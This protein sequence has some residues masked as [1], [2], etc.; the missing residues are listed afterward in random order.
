MRGPLPL[1][2]ILKLQYCL[3]GV[4]GFAICLWVTW[5]VVASG[6]ALLAQESVKEFEGSAEA[7]RHFEQEI[8]PLLI[9]KCISCHGE[10]KQEGGLRLDSHEA[11]LKGGESGSLL[12]ESGSADDS[13][14]L[15]A[16][17]YE[18]F[19]MPP[20]GPLPER[21]VAQFEKWL[22]TGAPWPEQAKL[23]AESGSIT[24]EDRQWW[25]FQP[26][27][28]AVPPAL[29]DS[30]E[31]RFVRNPIDQFVVA[32]LHEK[33]M[34]PAEQAS[35]EVLLRRLYFD[36]LGVPPS[37][38]EVQEFMADDAAD[39]W[40]RRV[41]QLL[42]DPRYGEHWARFW[43]DLV[44]Y[45][46]SDG[47]NQDAYRPHI[48]RYRDYVVR[49]FN[50]DKPYSQ[51]V[52]EQLAGDEIGKDNPDHWIATGF[53]RLGIYE[54]N[55][56]DARGHWND[57]MNEMTD[58]AGDVFLGLSMACARCHDHK[59]DPIP[60]QDYFKL[61]SFFEPISWRDDLVAATREQKQVYK[62]ELAR[63]R[64]ATREIQAEI[65]A[66]I[67]PYHKK[68][69]ISTVD[70][71]PLDIQACFHM[72][73]EQR[74]SWQNQ[75]AYLVFRQFEE[76]GGGPLKSMSKEDKVK[77]A[78]LLKRLE[79]FSKLKPKPLPA[80][81]AATDFD[82]LSS[83]TTVPEDA[84]R[85]AVEPGYLR[86]MAELES[87]DVQSLSHLERHST[88][89]RTALAKW[90]GDPL[91]PLTN[92]VIVN[93]I[94]QQHFGSGLVATPS[95]LGTQGQLP[96]HP[97]LLDWLTQQFV[98]SGGSLKELHK[99]ILTSATWQQSAE[100]AKAESYQRADPAESLLW[101]N[102]VRRLRAEQIR[103][104][105]LTA[106]GEMSSAIGGPSVSE[107][108]PRRALYVKSFRN[109]NENFLHG[110]D[111][112]GGLQSVAVRDRTTTATQALLMFNGD[113]ALG[114]A[115]AMAKR[116]LKESDSSLTAIEMCFWLTWNRAP[117]VRELAGATQYLGLNAGE[118]SQ[119]ALA[120]E[121]LAD[122]CHV[123]F[124]SSQFLY[125]E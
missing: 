10:S 70:K 24:A 59:F 6:Q 13:L 2:L 60:Q 71:F 67:E 62:V 49:A 63:Y 114:R 7:L 1:S 108:S 48:W 83:P 30:V 34:L 16:L 46:E 53:L 96:T 90:I 86:V 72:P 78:E 76:E 109:Q 47:W 105:M 125:V 29:P 121:D 81:M 23:R 64:E 43:L 98:D 44:R 65:D 112:V 35:K 103:D 19:E 9:S 33:E 57:I 58:V 89:R 94:W 75:M 119:D 31:P 111:M 39:A 15:E 40:E 42:D 69:W 41:Q 99:L 101:R 22:K 5:A 68:K 77:H 117:T 110:F 8:R 17:R 54:Y 124:N 56:R 95:D 85:K 61:R 116:V 3:P 55:Q 27:T 92:R 118:Q 100:H 122:F 52:R 79:E 87:G 80:M 120:E 32:R 25:A 18:S 21:S 4:L 91:N 51:F 38:G 102:S 84:S 113:Y 82:G 12:A 88:G 123:L 107:T 45:A 97:E 50:E 66:L 74:T 26:F 37:P 11:F 106:S 28:G 104:A 93:R 20:T 115:K 14:L 36:L 73:I